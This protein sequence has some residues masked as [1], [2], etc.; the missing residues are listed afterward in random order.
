[1]GKFKGARHDRVR[2]SDLVAPSLPRCKYSHRACADLAPT[3]GCFK[4]RS[5]RCSLRLHLSARMCLCAYSMATGA[6]RW[7][8]FAI[9]TCQFITTTRKCNISVGN[10]NI[11]PA[12]FVAVL[13]RSS[14]VQ[15]SGSSHDNTPSLHTAP[16]FSLCGDAGA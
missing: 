4:D 3:L 16:F 11:N 6:A 13:C 14:C 8:C 2:P 5:V 1:M 12:C 9:F 15:I 10:P 7:R